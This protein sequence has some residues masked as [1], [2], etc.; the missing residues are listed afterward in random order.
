[1][2][3]FSQSVMFDSFVTPWTVAVQAPLSV[4]FSRQEYWSELPFPFPEHLPDPGIKP[5]SP[6]LAG[7]FFTTEPAGKPL[8]NI[9]FIL[10]RKLI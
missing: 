10:E 6:A 7:R 3:L 1:M 4:G 2:L 8:E 5:A 9:S